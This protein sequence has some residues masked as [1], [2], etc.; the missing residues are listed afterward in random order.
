MANPLCQR[1]R[2]PLS[3]PRRQAGKR[4]CYRCEV[5]VRRESRRRA[6]D[7]A[8]ESMD[9]TAADYWALYE[10]QDGHCVVHNCRA[11]G[12]SRHLAVEH[13][14][15]CEMGHDKNRWCRACVRGLA[16]V[17]HNEWIGRAGDDPEVFDSLAAY[18]RNPPALEILMDRMFVGDFRKTLATLHDE[19]RIPWERGRKMLDLA[20]GVGPSPRP[21]PDGTI[22]IRYIRIPRTTKELYEIVESAP[23]LTA[24]DALA[25][26]FEYG[27]SERRAKT[28]LNKAWENDEH[29]VSTAGGIVRITYHGRGAGMAYMYS[30]EV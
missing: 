13:D 3:K 19:Y 17:T 5:A 14:H 7:R 27:L 6:H 4:K 20:R 29:K 16:C 18:L 11:Q 2:N 10:A 25:R 26:L 9:F 30:V 22:E 23:R 8:V 1:C 15:S 24:E 12:K 21:V 28:A